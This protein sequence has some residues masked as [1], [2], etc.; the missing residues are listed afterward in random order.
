MAISFRSGGEVRE[1]TAGEVTD[2]VGLLAEVRLDVGRSRDRLYRHGERAAVVGPREAGR[3]VVGKRRHVEA[4]FAL[5]IESERPVQK[6]ACPGVLRPS[7]IEN[8]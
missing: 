3:E 2:E 7:V 5:V 4:H 1:M 8:R 6:T